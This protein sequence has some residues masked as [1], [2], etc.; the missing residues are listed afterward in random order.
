MFCISKDSEKTK[1]CWPGLAAAIWS[2]W[3]RKEG[4][5]ISKINMKW[6]KGVTASLKYEMEKGGQRISET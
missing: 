2:K 4:Q 6:R 3:M 5:G 1:R